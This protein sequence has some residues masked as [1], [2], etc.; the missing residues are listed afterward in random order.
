MTLLT[1]NFT[2]FLLGLTINLVQQFNSNLID[3]NHK[4]INKNTQYLILSIIILI[5]NITFY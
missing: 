5:N 4:S 3:I 1:L 2:T